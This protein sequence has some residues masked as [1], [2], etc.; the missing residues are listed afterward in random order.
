ML[1]KMHRSSEPNISKSSNSPQN[2]ESTT[3]IAPQDYCKYV[4][5][6]ETN[7]AF[8]IQENRRRRAEL[9]KDVNDLIN[10]SKF[11]Q[12]HYADDFVT[13]NDFA[14][15]KNDRKSNANASTKHKNWSCVT[16]KISGKNERHNLTKR[17]AVLTETDAIC[18]Q[19][20]T[21][22]S[23]D[24]L[25]ANTALP[26]VFDVDQLDEYCEYIVDDFFNAKKANN[27]T[28]DNVKL[29]KHE[30][31]DHTKSKL[32]LKNSKY[33]SV[34]ARYLDQV[35][36]K[37]CEKLP[38]KSL[39]AR[40]RLFSAKSKSILEEVNRKGIKIKKH[41]CINHET[42]AVPNRKVIK[43]K[44]SARSN[45]SL[46]NFQKSH[47]NIDLVPGSSL[48]PKRIIK[49][50]NAH[51]KDLLQQYQNDMREVNEIVNFSD[52]IEMPTQSNK[53]EISSSATADEINLYV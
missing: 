42:E 2:I 35:P 39:T 20:T 45:Q 7:I 23:N 44:L 1:R 27:K 16:S 19:T 53:T 50:S 26:P 52:N 5:F 34:S 49:I 33:A 13:G 29:E 4:T 6:E 10:I 47:P 22:D 36:K 41:S 46:E 30:N 28:N 37:P 25:E 12:Q 38:H 48:F 15:K 18:Q 32:S 31:L 9:A 24:L 3:T 21:A 40:S 8:D 14:N 51:N 43:K 11:F 17:V